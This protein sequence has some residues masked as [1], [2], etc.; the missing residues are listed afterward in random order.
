MSLDVDAGAFQDL[1]GLT[2]LA[3]T[4]VTVNEFPD[5]IPPTVL[6]ATLDYSK[7][8]SGCGFIRCALLR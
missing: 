8:G 6:N 5:L 7:G 4:N 1:V 3:F 2:N